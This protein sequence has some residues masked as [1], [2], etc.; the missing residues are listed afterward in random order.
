MAQLDWAA[1]R[2]DSFNECSG[3]ETKQSDSEV[4]VNLAL[5]GERITSSLPSLS[6]PL[7]AGVLS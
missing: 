5:W 2:K 7:W 6:C 3:Y 1:V 4:P